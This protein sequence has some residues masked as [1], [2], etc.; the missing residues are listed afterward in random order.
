[1]AERLWMLR[2]QHG[3]SIMGLALTNEERFIASCEQVSEAEVRNRLSAGRYSERKAEWASSWLEK[4][5]S[6]KSDATKAEERSARLGDPTSARTYF[7]YAVSAI[8]MV[9][10]LAGA[11][12]FLKLR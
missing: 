4:V 10:L 7:V 3:A 9:L 6:G 11:A 8:L 1:M 2:A 5:E 12:A